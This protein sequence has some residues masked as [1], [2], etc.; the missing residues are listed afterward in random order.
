MKENVIF[1]YGM[2]LLFNGDS[3]SLINE[4]QDQWMVVYT[5]IC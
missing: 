4:H 1:D 5:I 2:W 3:M